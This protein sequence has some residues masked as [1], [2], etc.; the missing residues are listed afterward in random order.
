[1]AIE[2]D[3]KFIHALWDLKDAYNALASILSESELTNHC[4]KQSDIH[5][6]LGALNERF[7][8]LIESTDSTAL[9]L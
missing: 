7:S 9:N 4:I 8:D 6:L 3:T 2:Q 1:M 5:S